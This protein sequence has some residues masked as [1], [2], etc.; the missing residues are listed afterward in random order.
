MPPRLLGLLSAMLAVMAASPAR[1]ASTYDPELEYRAITTPHFQVVFPESYHAL[2][3]RT[4]SRAEGLFSYLA[5][6]YRWVPDGRTTIII[7][8][9]TDFANGSATIVPNKVVTLYVTQPTEI[10]GLED[11]DDWLHA[12]L[13]H[14]LAHVFHLD[15]AYGLPAI[16][17]WIFGKYVSMNLYAPTWAIEGLAVYEETVSSGAGRG[18]SSYVDMVLRTA[19]LADRFPGIDQGYRGFA[20]WPFGNVAYMFGG[21]FQLWL[22]RRYGEDALL[23]YHRAYASDPIPYFTYLPAQLAFDESLESLWAAFEAETKEDAELVRRQ[24]QT[25]TG[26]F[27]SPERLTEYGGD[28]SG[29]RYTPDGRWI[30]FSTDSPKDGSRVRRIPTDGTAE[31]EDVL[32]DDTF[33]KAIS[34]SPDGR[35][36]YF[37]QT[38]IN[39]RYYVHN[40]LVAYDLE[41]E[42]SRVLGLLPACAEPPP[43]PTSSATIYARAVASGA[44]VATASSLAQNPWMPDRRCAE[45]ALYKAYVAPSGS[46]RARDPDASPDGRR[47]VFVQAPFAMNRLVVADLDDESGALVN[48]RVLIA[49]E[50]DVQLSS[51]RWSPDGNLIALSRFSGGRRDVQLYDRDGVLVDELTR[52]R[53]LDV[54]PTWSPDARWL[55]FAS[56]R[57][58]IA[59][60]YAFD[61]ETRTYRQLTHVVTGAYQPSVSPDGEQLVFRGYS[62]DG[63]DVYRI[64]F[65]PFDAPIVSWSLDPPVARDEL[66]RRAPA[67]HP[68]LPP[69]PPRSIGSDGPHDFAVHDYSS[70]DTLLPFQDNWNLFP[71]IAVNERE[72]FARV[73]TFGSDALETQSYALWAEYGTATQFVGGGASYVNDQLEP[74]FALSLS[75]DV[76]S[77]PLFDPSRRFLDYYEQQRYTGALTIGVPVLQRHFISVGYTFEHRRLWNELSDQLLAT[78]SGL[79]LDGNFARVRLG[80]RYSNAR[81]FAHSVS[82]ERGVQAAIAIEGLSKGLGSDYEQMVASADVRHYLTLPWLNNHVL[83]SRLFLRAGFGNDLA[84]DGYLG[85]VTGQSVLTTTT[86]DLFPL[87]GLVTAGLGGPVLVAGS[88]EYRA[89]LWRIER[90]LGT[91]PIAVRVLHAA[92]YFD[93]GR[94]LDGVD[95]DGDPDLGAFFGG[96]AVG[97]G[98]ELRADILLGYTIGLDLRAGWAQLLA[99][100]EEGTDASGFYFQIGSTF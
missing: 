5:A 69:L 15:M 23:H 1:A 61:L 58:G 4:A 81:R 83:A 93:Y 63:F 48:P 100:P 97:T 80:Y 24:V 55:V 74:T 14:E 27:P 86:R 64:P 90:G 65:R 21:R 28:L 2:A 54:D 36:A 71:L 29:P 41:A 42:T 77:F 68:D 10:S 82:L 87:R 73:T 95:I 19:A 26:A 57:T 11:Y 22:A 40:S 67:P 84:D 43:V 53:A 33:S 17:R 50:A 37:Q 18:R 72:L 32:L 56:D 98:A 39:E 49:G 3:A 52:D 44:D 6:R 13:V 46:L 70:L 76:G 91:L 31:D 7:N 16:G 85:G 20:D 99:T 96:F 60:L 94:V 75:T 66:P 92:A 9:Q 78:A 35:Y 89:P 62:A 79:P 30:V 88:F 51:P 25:A 8:D 45:R 47:V 12:V 38:A 34:F 59:N